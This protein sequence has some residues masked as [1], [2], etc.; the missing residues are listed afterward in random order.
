MRS[1]QSKLGSGLVFSLMIAFSALWLLVSFNAQYLSEEY[2]VTRLQHDSEILL[3]NVSFDQQGDLQVDQSSGG[4]IYQQPFSGY[5]FIIS[6]GETTLY[7]RSLWDYQLAFKPLSLG[8]TLRSMQQGP[9]NQWLL[10]IS[11]GF[12]KQGHSL[13]ITVA[14]DLNPI[15][16]NISRFKY[17]FALMAFGFLF[18]LVVV[19]IFLL[20]SSLRPLKTV[21]SELKSLEQGVKKKMSAHVPTELVPLINEVNHLL[22]ILEHRQHRSRHA[23]SDLAHALK[24]PLTVIQQTINHSDIN[25][26]VKNS[27]Q[28][29]TDSIFHQTDRILKKARLSGSTQSGILFSFET[30]FSD[31]IDTLNAMYMSKT[32]VFDM[33]I[34]EG[35]ISPMEREDMLELLGNLLDNGYKWAEKRVGFSAEI[36]DRYLKIVIE[37][38]GVGSEAAM[39][40]DL[41]ERG[42]RLD[43]TVQGHGFGLAIATDIVAEYE[44]QYSVSSIKKTWGFK[45]LIKLPITL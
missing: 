4:L 39:A 11:R 33:A 36:I 43:E 37:D 23:L 29:Q 7:S 34:G 3:S 17:W 44:R 2:I 19:Q 8:E 12:S 10:M 18:I 40:L 22:S 9:N 26:C 28:D 24:K 30:D 31:L 41:S 5:Y 45:A 32:I 42:V 21:Q 15:N 27:L 14:E 38:D 20:R 16:Q 6:Q 13:T 35:I 1:I 25:L